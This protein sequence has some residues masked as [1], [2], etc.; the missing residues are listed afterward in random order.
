MKDGNKVRTIEEF[1]TYFVINPLVLFG[2]NNLE[3][4]QDVCNQLMIE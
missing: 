1:R 3:C 4:M 2:G